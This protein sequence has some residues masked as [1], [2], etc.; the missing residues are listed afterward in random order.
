MADYMKKRF[1]DRLTITYGDSTETLPAFRRQHP[2]VKC[3]LMIAD[4]GH[5]SE[6]AS[7]D[8][9]HF[10]QMANRMN[11]VLYDNHPDFY[12][13]GESWEVLKRRGVLYEYFRCQ[14][15]ELKAH[16][17]TFGRFIFD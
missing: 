10:Y 11:I 17:F 13:L 5:T 3:D 9:G 16:G 4:G 14:Y 8:F 1:P 2:D 7:S 12:D 15:I 6:I